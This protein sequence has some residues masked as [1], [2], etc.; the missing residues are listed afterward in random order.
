MLE[1]RRLGR[2]GIEASLLGF[3][4]IPIM[5]V[6]ME[7][8]RA[9]IAEA[10]ASGVNLI[11]TARGYGDSEEKIGHALRSLGARP[12]L[13][14]KSPK[15]DAGGL[16]E[17]FGISLAN[18]G[19]ESID[20]YQVHCVNTDEQYAKVVDPGG[21][22][23]ALT[24]LK[25]EGKL[26]HIGFTTHS[27]ALAS[28]AV[29]SGHFDTIQ[30]LYNFIEPEAGTEVI[31]LAMEKDIGVLAMKPFA[32]GCIE[33][34]DLALRFALAVPG[35]IA[36]PGMATVDEVRKNVEVAGRA[37]ALSAEEIKIAAAE[38]ERL[39]TVYCRRCDYCQPCP[40]EIPIAFAMHI[41]SIRKRMGDAMMQTDLIKGA[42]EKVGN[43]TECGECEDRCPFDLPVRD[44]IKEA[45]RTLDE[46]LQSR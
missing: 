22:L 18:L 24:K 35:V 11:D 7:Q 40:S 25:T 2:T 16:L 13:A 32:G 33:R 45:R 44:L 20:L 42:H 28:K 21:A 34:C 43:C 41:P 17:D 23:E 9:T 6:G 14:S 8:A 31:P 37:E 15:R 4:G 27:L 38:K 36:I 29:A 3:G 10:L 5:R 12:F 1:T 26:Q 46:I 19:V 30:V 39:G